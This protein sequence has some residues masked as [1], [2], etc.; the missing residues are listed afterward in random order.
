VEIRRRVAQ[1][2]RRLSTTES[3]S[4]AE[5][6]RFQAIQVR[7]NALCERWDR[8]QT[9]KEAGRRPGI[10][11]HFVR[12]GGSGTE[13]P[14]ARA[15]A[16]EAASVREDEETGTRIVQDPEPDRE[17]FRRYIEAKRVRGEDVADLRFDRFAEK[18]ADQREKL[19]EH[20]G[21]A[22]IVFDVAERDGRVRLVAKPKE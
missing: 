17:L 6:F 11:S 12:L 10:Y 16:R 7:Y 18:L 13:R 19:R 22:E 15:N 21:D 8:L 9:E 2:I 3:E 14:P 5:R 1:Q 20:F 4:A